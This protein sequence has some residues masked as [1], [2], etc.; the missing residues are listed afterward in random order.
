MATIMEATP[1]F[2]LQ[3]LIAEIDD[4]FARLQSTEKMGEYVKF[5]AVADL[6]LDIR[7]KAS[8]LN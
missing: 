7:Q 6:I 5:D 1:A 2:D 8:R 3:S 4:V